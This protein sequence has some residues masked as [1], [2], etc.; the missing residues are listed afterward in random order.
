VHPDPPDGA[1]RPWV[2]KTAASLAEIRPVLTS[3]REHQDPYRSRSSR[4]GEWPFWVGDE[5]KGE[6]T[7]IGSE[8]H[9]R[10][11]ATTSATPGKTSGGGGGGVVVGNEIEL[12][13]DAEATL[14][15]DLKR[16]GAIE[17]CRE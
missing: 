10:S 9:R 12:T 3:G 16:T 1:L 7:R 8:A 11:T 4:L 2:A 14:V 5:N 6:L 17:Y 13:L 15:E